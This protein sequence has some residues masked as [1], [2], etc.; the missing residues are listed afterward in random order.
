M[1]GTGPRRLADTASPA[2]SN[3]P[4]TSER[5]RSAIGDPPPRDLSHLLP[6]WSA[7]SEGDLPV[8]QAAIEGTVELVLAANAPWPAREVWR[9]LIALGF[10]WGALELFHL[11]GPLGVETVY[12]VHALTEPF[13]FL[14]ERAA[15][16]ERIHGLVLACDP[17]AHPSIVP[18]RR[19]MVLALSALATLLGGRPVDRA[20]TPLDATDLANWAER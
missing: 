20:G 6:A 5:L 18:V 13:R 11:P 1:F 3:P 10:R 7:P 17:A 15:E 8:G 2:D 19:H 12:H 14:P 9:A 4:G 16:G